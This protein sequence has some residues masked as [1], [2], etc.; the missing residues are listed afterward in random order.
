MKQQDRDQ[1]LAAVEQIN[2]PDDLLRHHAQLETYV[3][4]M[5]GA[6][7]NAKAVI[8]EIEKRAAVLT[9]GDDPNSL[10]ETFVHGVVEKVSKTVHSVA[11]WEK[12]YQWIA[13]KPLERMQGF[14][15][16]KE[17]STTIRKHLEDHGELP[18]GCEERVLTDIKVKSAT[19]VGEIS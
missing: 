6:V 12:Y 2:S 7:K 5:G 19:P 3:K 10:G 11:D 17:G 14:L 1:W 4:S 18:P 15:H 13:E 16:K 8:E 9:L